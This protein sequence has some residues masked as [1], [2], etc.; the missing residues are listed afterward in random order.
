MLPQEVQELAV[1]VVQVWQVGWQGWQD[2]DWRVVCG[3]QGLV[4]RVPW[5]SRPGLQRR[6]VDGEVHSRQGDTHA[7]QV[8][9][10]P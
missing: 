6:Q 10:F 3:G 2:W 8:V 7:T 9:P 4:Q 1:G 5:R